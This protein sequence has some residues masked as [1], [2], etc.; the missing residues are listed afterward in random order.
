MQS[1]GWIVSQAVSQ[2]K[3]YNKRLCGC[4]AGSLGTAIMVITIDWVA[5]NIGQM[6]ERL[7]RNA[8]QVV[9]VSDSVVSRE[10]CGWYFGKYNNF[11]DYVYS[12]YHSCVSVLNDKKRLIIPKMVN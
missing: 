7:R 1:G 4:L 10:C 8:G 5:S 3:L 6:D 12:S 9:T 11:I 2:C